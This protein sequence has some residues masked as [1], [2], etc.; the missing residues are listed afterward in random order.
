MKQMNAELLLQR[1]APLCAPLHEAL[2]LG[3]D[4]ARDHLKT[5]GLIDG[6]WRWLATH[7]TRGHAIA[8]LRESPIDGW[9]LRRSNTNGRLELTDESSLCLRMLH[10]PLGIVPAPGHNRAR[11]AFYQNSLHLPGFEQSNLL[12]L[13]TAN[14]VGVAIKVVRPVG[15]WKHQQKAKVDLLVDL[16]DSAEDLDDLMFKIDDELD[17]DLPA[18]DVE[19]EADDDTARG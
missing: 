7:I 3:D 14:E 2:A 13:W 18:N 16:P 5:H 12:G 8:H 9:K 19:G 15:N 1:L 10:D 17:L 6:E 4:V 11:Q